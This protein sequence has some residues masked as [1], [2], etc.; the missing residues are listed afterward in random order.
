MKLLI[1]ATNLADGVRL[2]LA[3]APGDT[4][5]RLVLVSDGNENIDFVLHMID[6]ARAQLFAQ[7]PST[8][9]RTL[10]LT[11]QWQ[12]KGTEDALKFLSTVVKS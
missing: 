5:N 8:T 10:S 11:E 2:A 3:M 6:L 12:A 4:A 1:S 7:P 9:E